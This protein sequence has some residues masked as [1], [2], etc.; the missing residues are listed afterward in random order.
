MRP[1]FVNRCFFNVL[2]N[3]LHSGLCDQVRFGYLLCY[4]CFQI[5]VE[6]CNSDMSIPVVS[7]GIADVS[8]VD[9]Q[10]LIQRWQWMVL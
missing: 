7:C 10:I 8:H 4:T 3:V 9:R 2:T 1:F 5:Q 6:T